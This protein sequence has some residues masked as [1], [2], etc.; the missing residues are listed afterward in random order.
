MH[1]AV[2]FDLDGTLVDSSEG[3]LKAAREALDSLDINDVTDEQ[4]RACIGPPIGESLSQ[5]R[6]FSEEQKRQFYDVF[7]PTYRDK[8]LFQCSLYPG[9]VSLIEGLKGRG[10]VVGIVTNKKID[11]TTLLLDHLGIASLFDVV[12]AQDN[13][14]TK[15]KSSMIVHALEILKI[16]K[17]EA[18]MVGDSNNDLDAAK[19]AGVSFIGVR[20]G[21]GLKETVCSD[22]LLVDTV[23]ELKALFLE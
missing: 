6:G 7:R 3:I 23:D 22:V 5:V 19:G 13:A 4:I 21:F 10:H 17:D 1:K 12:V 9:I 8:Y 15:E 20:Y 2:L 18:V 11:S 16:S 14:V